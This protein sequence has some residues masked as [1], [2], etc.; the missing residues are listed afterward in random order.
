MP[1]VCIDGFNIA[2]PKGSGIATYG[3]NLLSNLDAIGM[4][5]QVLYGPQANFSKRPILNEIALTDA[6]VPESRRLRR[7]FEAATARF[8]RT[9]HAVPPTGDVIWPARG[10]GRPTASAFWSAPRL[11]STANRAFK[12]NGTFTPV[13]FARHDTVPRPDVVHWTT[14]LPLAARGTANIYTIHDLIPLRL[15]HTTLDNKRQ[16]LATCQ[17]MVRRADHIAVV[18]EATRRDVIQL[19]GVDEHRITTTWQS[20]SI[21]PA[22]R[23]ASDESVA[24]ELEG[25]FNLGWKGYFLYFGA[26]EPKKNLAR[27]VEAYLASGSSLPLVVVGG[28]AWLEAD[29]TAL[30]HQ[31]WQDENIRGKRLRVYD[32]LPFPMLVNLIRGAR[33]TLFPSLYEGFGLPVLESMLL[34]TP[35]ITSTAASLP[36]V[37]GDAA[38]LVDPY[39]VQALAREIRRLGTDDDLAADL[40]RRGPVQ[41][42]RF[43]PEVCQGRLADMYGRLGIR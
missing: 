30:M 24:T 11:F 4:E 6:S 35:V 42:A 3:R 27:I 14:V 19:L 13:S 38:I 20:V 36:E 7:E 43:S 41:A 1:T 8:G 23:S 28:R 2:L 5:T 22:L 32:F 21:P 10:S 25:V 26:I 33:G 40:S 16:F 34:G 12:R 39:D 31:A 37:A 9:A 17:Q 18:S 29:E 15:P